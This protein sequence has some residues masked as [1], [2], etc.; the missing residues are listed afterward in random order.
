MAKQPK[1]RRYIGARETAGYILFDWAS[2]F[3]MGDMG[4]MFLSRVLN[5][6]LGMRTLIQTFI[7]GPWDVV[8][9]LWFSTVVDKTRTRFGKFRPYLFLSLLAGVPFKLFFYIMPFLFWGTP[10][11]YPPKLIAYTVLGILSEATGTFNGLSRGGMLATLT[12]DM[13]DRTRLITLTSFVNNFT[14]K[15]LP[16]YIFDAIV[17]YLNFSK[18]EDTVVLLKL[19]NLCMVFGVGTATLAGLAAI[20]FALVARERV[21]Q[22]INPPR[23]R[24][25]VKAILQ[26]RPLLIITLARLFGTFNIGSDGEYTYYQ[27]VLKFPLGSTVAGVPGAIT[28]Y[29]AYPYIPRARQ[30]FSTRVLWIVGSH[31]RPTLGI[32]VYFLGLINNNFANIWAILPIIAIWEATWTPLLTIRNIIAADLRNAC[33]DYGEW[34]T[35]LRNEAMI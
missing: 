8:N 9:D 7:I 25:S 27:A 4:E 3:E 20:Y 23:L 34:K 10:P 2:G 30:R 14:G 24:D 26:N 35:G 33:M 13:Y 21:P 32:V 29:L 15:K 6:D 11:D 22:T 5:L 28:H 17:T 19:R 31:V 18:M 16:A 1:G 12:P